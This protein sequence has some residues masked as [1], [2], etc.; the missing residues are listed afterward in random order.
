MDRA[1]RRVRVRAPAKINLV[2]AVGPL[3]PDGYHELATIFHAVS[4][5]DEVVV[6]PADEIMVSVHGVHADQVPVDESN[7]AWRAA[8]AIARYTGVRAGVRLDITKRIPVAAGLAGG[9]ADAAAALVACDALWDTGLG[10]VE[11]AT[12]SARLGSDVPFS[13]VGGTALGAGR[14]EQLT[15]VMVGGT[16]H[17]V[18][19]AADGGLSTPNVYAELDRL[20]D[21][22]AGIEPPD[23][24][25]DIVTALR[26]G[27]PEALG[28]ALRNDLQEPA[29]SLRPDLEETLSTGHALGAL[30]GVVSGSGPTCAFLA[31]DAAHADELAAGLMRS[32]AATEVHQASGPVPGARLA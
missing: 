3:R 8:H 7:L 30:G 10:R 16:F 22:R 4:V 25:T 5:H 21:T 2:L 9:S 31:R 12:L 11:L 18:L 13:L 27:D 17:W 15:P 29:L 24:G 6:S 14:G 26:A 1:E 19:V 32:G 20:R 28:L 23:V